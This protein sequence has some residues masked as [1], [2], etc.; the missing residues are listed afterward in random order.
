MRLDNDWCLGVFSVQ[1]FDVGA[2][3]FE[4]DIPS[5]DDDPVS[6][7]NSDYDALFVRV[8]V[9]WLVV[10]WL[11]DIDA[12][13]LDERRSDDKEDQHD[14]HHVQHRREVDLL[15]A[16]LFLTTTPSS[17]GLPF[18]PMWGN[19]TN[20]WC[21]LLYREARM[22]SDYR[23]YAPSSKVSTTPTLFSTLRIDVT[24]AN[25]FVDCAGDVFC[26][27]AKN[28]FATQHHV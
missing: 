16:F 23:N 14:E 10:F 9:R 2:Y 27:G 19:A 8:Y 24:G 20:D 18:L 17:H 25:I 22:K 26:N 1:P 7:C 12:N 21:R 13:L 5:P 4:C 28:S 6:T 11:I 15:V 3:R